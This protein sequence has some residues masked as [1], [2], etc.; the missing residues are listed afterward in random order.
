MLFCDLAS[1][2][3][4]SSLLDAELLRVIL[5][6]YYEL[7]RKHVEAHG[8]IVEKFIGDA[9]VAV[10]GLVATREDDAHRALTAAIAMMGAMAGLNGELGRDHG[11]RL[12]IRIGVHTGQVVTTAD[13]GSRQ[14]LV[15][16][17]VVNIA[18]RLEQAAAPGQVLISAATAR[19][20]GSALKVVPV[21][22]LALKG[23]SQQVEAV[24]L[25]EVLA[26]PSDAMRRFDVP[27]VGRDKDLSAL[28]LAWDR[29]AVQG[30][31]HLLT[32]LGEAGIGKTRLAAEWLRRHSEEIG[33]VGTGRC[34]SIGA[35]GSLMALADCVAPLIA[36]LKGQ[37]GGTDSTIGAALALLES[38]ALLDGAPSPSTD[39][40]CAALAYVLA[41]VAS[42]RPVLLVIDDCQRA[43][44]TLIEML[45]RLME[46]LDRLPV[47]L[48]C[49]ARP[50]LIDAFP[51]WGSGRP[52]ATT[53]TIAGL[54][55]D[56]SAVLAASFADVAPHERGTTDRIVAQANGNPLYLEQL[57]TAAHEQGTG[58]QLP[59]N[60]YALLAARIDRLDA[61]ERTALQYAAVVGR[62]FVP[63]DL[64][65]LTAEA[66]AEDTAPHDYAA[67]LRALARRRFI[68]PLRTP[69]GAPPLY[70]FAN[71][72]M[73]RVAYEGL[74]KRT[75]GELHER[76]A[77]SL[78][79]RQCSDVV[80]G[81]HLE[82]AYRYHAE[83]SILDDR[84]TAL[85]RRAAEHL[86]RAGTS[87]LRRVDLPRAQTLLS[88]AVELTDQGEPCRPDWFQQLGAACLTLGRRDEAEQALR[89]A[90]AETRQH[91]LPAVAAHARLLLAGMRPE[92]AGQEKVARRALPTFAATGDDLGLARSQLILARS[93]QRRGRHAK[94]LDILDRA[95]VHS[96]SAQADQELANTLGA[97]GMS[98]WCGPDPAPTAIERCEALL[99]A[100]GPERSAVQATLGF[101]LTILYAVQGRFAQADERL[102][103]TH[104]AMASL[105]YADSHVFRPL[106]TALVAVAGD[107][108][109]RAETAL[110]QALDAARVLRATGL[111]H[112]ISLELARL[113]L[114]QSRWQ[115]SAELVA[116]LEIG[117]D[118]PADLASYLGIRAWIS[119]FGADS[120]AAFQLADA[121]RAVASR[122]D[123]PTVQAVAFLDR[124]S[125]AVLLG[126]RLSA[127]AA[128]GAALRRFAAKGDLPGVARTERLVARALH[129][130]GR[131]EL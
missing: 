123:S 102:A 73:L 10:F 12:D 2:S 111:I 114:M 31:A 26:E 39:E 75:R 51:A 1:S 35:G 9:I 97:I 86:A 55:A 91:G 76:Y 19:A 127:R 61:A 16:G 24:R 15:S 43:E 45:N 28:D 69:F 106:L 107:Q 83:V 112:T 77:E 108:E 48:I 20:A 68:A 40:T 30:D 53:V 67:T 126:K 54:S 131:S 96:L 88:R 49:L 27:F 23:I 5:L 116:D 50:E 14:A 122:T 42:E 130:G 17:E 85:R 110:N 46:D 56:E 104:R 33:T 59:P 11:L 62:P 4:L 124:A 81:E 125:A 98:L 103:A 117:E 32:L 72:V 65:L 95:L 52:N 41:A 105:S 3:E 44:P 128:T 121:A 113:R 6:H 78:V 115:E 82:L 47:M 7:M 57:G 84:M 119:A 25:I 92:G 38:G 36:E 79:R 37:T 93:C 80:I 64:Q 120:D 89:R 70:C 94:A 22:R 90:I 18:A 100:H 99:A 34:Q 29:V 74:T 13:P 87:A 109:P 129:T 63:D 58:D 66:P 60:L 8:G 71:V 101:P 118:H 21:G